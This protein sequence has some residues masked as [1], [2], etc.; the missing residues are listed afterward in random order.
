MEHEILNLKGV[1]LT[2]RWALTFI[3]EI[4]HMWDYEEFKIK[5]MQGAGAHDVSEG[6]TM[7]TRP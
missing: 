7:N 1:G 5:N 2:P 6:R 3:Y 4:S